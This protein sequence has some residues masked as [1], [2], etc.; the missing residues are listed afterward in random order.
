MI[1]CSYDWNDLKYQIASGSRSLHTPFS[2][3]LKASFDTLHAEGVEGRPKIMVIGLHC[4]ISGKPGRFSAVESFVKYILE[5]RTL[6]DNEERDS[7]FI[8]RRTFHT[9][10]TVK[11]V[12]KRTE[13]SRTGSMV[14]INQHPTRMRFCSATCLSL[15]VR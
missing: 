14:I 5:R 6:V 11:D 3:Y 13:K 15:P 12:K 4:R 10:E 1:P 9:G 2:D 7:G 8:G